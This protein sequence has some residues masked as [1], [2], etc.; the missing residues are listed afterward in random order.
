[1]H[2]KILTPPKP[3]IWQPGGRQIAKLAIFG[4]EI[5]QMMLKCSSRSNLGCFMQFYMGGFY[6]PFSY[7]QCHSVGVAVLQHYDTSVVVS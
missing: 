2:S 4:Q 7:M 3:P 1:M 5:H 6:K